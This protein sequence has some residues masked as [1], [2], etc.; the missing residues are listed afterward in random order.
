MENARAA[1]KAAERQ[2][3][4]ASLCPDSFASNL[5]RPRQDWGG[6][7]GNKGE[8]S[9]TLGSEALHPQLKSPKEL[10]HGRRVQD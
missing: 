4:I 6:V 5:G 2:C 3:A 1:V 8:Q 7:R 10:S 9:P